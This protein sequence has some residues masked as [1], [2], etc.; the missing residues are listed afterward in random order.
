LAFRVLGW[1]TIAAAVVLVFVGQQRI[2][3]LIEWVAERPPA[4]L[5][6][7]FLFGV[8]FGAFLMHAAY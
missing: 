6:V 5:R 4:L 3:A 2:R 7:W 1:I 8:A